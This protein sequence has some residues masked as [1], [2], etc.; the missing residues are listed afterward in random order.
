MF[1]DLQEL[2][3]IQLSDGQKVALKEL[4]RRKNDTLQV[5]NPLPEDYYVEWGLFDQVEPGGLFLIPG[6]KHDIGFGPGKSNQPR[7]IATKFFK[8]VAMLILQSRQRVAIDAENDRRRSHGFARLNRTTD[9]DE[10]SQFLSQEGLMI[11]HD[12]YL[13]LLPIVI[14][15]IVHEWGLDTKPI[16]RFQRTLT[17]DE[18]QQITDR[19]IGSKVSSDIMG[20]NK[21]VEKQVETPVQAPVEAAPQ[22]QPAPEGDPLQGVAA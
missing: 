14:L 4:A 5:F 20:A 12:K 17:L 18:L 11:N 10:E 15:G 2:L 7:Y 1:D 22:E 9:N 16:K 21:V 3:G 6:A 8:E 19:K 13:E